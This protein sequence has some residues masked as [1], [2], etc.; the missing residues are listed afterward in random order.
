M[1]APLSDALN[2]GLEALSGIEVAGLPKF[3]SH[4]VFVPLDENDPLDAPGVERAVRDL[5][6]G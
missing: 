3:Q 4:I 5:H 2:Y 6:G 1:Y